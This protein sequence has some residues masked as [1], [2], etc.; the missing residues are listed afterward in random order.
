MRSVVIVVL[1]WVE[2]EYGVALRKVVVADVV[3]SIA[4]IVA[5]ALRRRGAAGAT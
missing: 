5:L 1:A 4:L 2:G 3:A